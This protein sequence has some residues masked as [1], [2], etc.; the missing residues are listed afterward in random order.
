MERLSE[1]QFLSACVRR[2]VGIGSTQINEG[3]IYKRGIDGYLPLDREA[4]NRE[5]IVDYD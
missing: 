2:T 4:A 3:M 5:Y 1:S